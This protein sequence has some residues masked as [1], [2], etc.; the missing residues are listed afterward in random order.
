MVYVE[1]V[2]FMIYAV[3]VCMY[4]YVVDSIWFVVYELQLRT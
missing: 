3:C 2:I 1:Y 4:Y